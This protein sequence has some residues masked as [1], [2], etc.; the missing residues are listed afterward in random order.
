[1]AK[2]VIT[3]RLSREINKRF[4]EESVSV[5]GLMKTLE[6]NP[7][8]GKLVGNISDIAIK[9]IK[10][11]SSRLYFITDAYKV[12]FLSIPELEN[13]IIKF[14]RMSDKKTQQKTIDGI[15]LLLR[16]LGHT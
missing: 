6:E 4:K 13:L 5:F 9:E 14:V 11:K 16:K 10:Y 2:V 1:M 7:K 15:K 3:K 12:K 8:K